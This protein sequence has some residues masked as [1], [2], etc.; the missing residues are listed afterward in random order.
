VSGAYWLG[1]GLGVG[2]ADANANARLANVINNIMTGF[3][4]G[5]T[6]PMQITASALSSAV[7]GVGSALNP[8]SL[9]FF[10]FQIAGGAAAGAGAIIG[11]PAS[12]LTGDLFDSFS[13]AGG[14]P[15]A[16]MNGIFTTSA[17]GAGY[18]R[19]LGADYLN[20]NSHYGGAGDV[21]QILLDTVG[22]ITTPGLYTAAAA[23]NG[24]TN[25]V[26]HSQGTATGANGLRLIPSTDRA[27]ISVVG[28]GG[29][30]NLNAGWFGF[31]SATNLTAT[32]DPVPYLSPNN[33]LWRAFPSGNTTNTT[34]PNAVPSLSITNHDFNTVYF[35]HVPPRR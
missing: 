28:A 31:G 32:G 27:N 11:V 24:T 5:L 4:F 10:A 17:T 19:N 2:P 26:F 35:P 34:V 20:N 6:A 13:T 15:R 12:I 23:Q 9:N 21:L 3:V 8:L 7:S 30:W 18:A 22:I 25:F 14:A 16:F 1:V 29:Q 33:F